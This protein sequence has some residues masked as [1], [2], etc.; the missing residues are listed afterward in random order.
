MGLLQRAW[1]RRD[2]HTP[3]S[4]LKK[5]NLKFGVIAMTPSIEAYS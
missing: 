4:V 5:E 1:A 2:P 3:F